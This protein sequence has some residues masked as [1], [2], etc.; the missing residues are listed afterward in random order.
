MDSQGIVV[1]RRD[2][3]PLEGPAPS[4]PLSSRAASLRSDPRVSDTWP[5][6]GPQR[7]PPTLEHVRDVRSLH[8]IQGICTAAIYRTTFGV[9]LRIEHDG[10]LIESRLSRVDAICS[11][12]W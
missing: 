1:V 3:S 11:L 2:Y 6:P 9:E 4:D 8:G 12:E 7:R 10:A 5:P